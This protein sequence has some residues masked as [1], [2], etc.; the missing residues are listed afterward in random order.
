M[1]YRIEE[2]ALETSGLCRVLLWLP[3][4]S[5]LVTGSY[6]PARTSGSISSGIR[7]DSAY[8]G[9]PT[10][11]L[12]FKR[13]RGIRQENPRTQFPPTKLARGGAPKGRVVEVLRAGTVGAGITAGQRVRRRFEP[14]G[15]TNQAGTR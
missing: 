8:P 7:S 15:A 1:L 14:L 4:P 2:P 10:A 5:L 9:P 12:H 11:G 3:L 13:R 6:I